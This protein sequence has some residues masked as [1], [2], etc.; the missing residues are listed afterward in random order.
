M[1]ARLPA[2]ISNSTSDDVLAGL[3]V[4]I[5]MDTIP[6]SVAVAVMRYDDLQSDEQTDPFPAEFDPSRPVM[7]KVASDDG[8][9]GRFRPSRRLI[10][11]CLESGKS[12]LHIWDCETDDGL[13]TVSGGLDWA[14]CTPVQ[15]TETNQWCLYVA[16]QGS[17]NQGVLIDD[18]ALKGDMRFVELVAQFI[19]SICNV[20]LLEEQKTQLSSFF[21]PLVIDS[22]L[23][24]E[25]QT[26]QPAQRDITVLFCDVR[27]FSHLSEM[28]QDDLFQLL[29]T[30]KRALG[31][32][33]N[34]ILESGGA[35]A[36]FQGDAALGFWGWPGPLKEGPVP[37]CRAAM[38]IVEAFNN[39]NDDSLAGVSV[40]IGIAHGNA[41]AGQIGTERQAK[42]GVFGPVVNQGSRFEGLTKQLG[43]SIC[44]DETTA[45]YVQS[46]V[47]EVEARCRRLVRIRPA[48]MDTPLTVYQ[49][50]PG[51]MVSE[52]TSNRMLK[53][54]DTALA[55]IVDGDWKSAADLLEEFCITDG[56]TRFLMEQMKQTELRPPEGWDGVFTLTKK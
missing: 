10:R 34:G 41:I 44:I 21:S 49:L 12:V 45:E 54:Y 8:Y 39:C 30:G 18:N 31:L 40:G 26:L 56:P 13:F 51:T 23:G 14:F 28:L 5:L 16:G 48:G 52:S 24:H 36:D 43:V 7:M 35:I 19:A 53:N 47:P 17:A 1:L 55:A 32:M 33:T 42:I 46:N 37:A 11:S 15:T 9:T 29:A 20:R 4:G 50:L 25:S 38:K 27:G 22:L 2:L 3:I 6:S